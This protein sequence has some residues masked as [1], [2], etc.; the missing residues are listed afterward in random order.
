MP[1]SI[2]SVLAALAAG[3]A[4]ALAA[5]T[6]CAQI[7]IGTIYSA[8]DSTLA[9][10]NAV[11]NTIEVLPEIVGAR[12]YRV[13]AANDEGVPANAARA[14]RKMIADDNVDVVIG[15]T[16][17]VTCAALADIA[18]E[19][20][21]AHLCLVQIPIRNPYVFA[22]AHPI[23]VMVEGIVEHMRAG[24]VKT[25]AFIGTADPWGDESFNQLTRQARDANIAVLSNERY[26]RT[27]KS[28]NP[29][30]LKVVSTQANA[31]MVGASDSASAALAQI[32]L[33]ERGYRGRVY[34]SH[35]ALVRSF[36]ETAGRTAEGALLPSNAFAVLI[37]L[38]E[39][40]TIRRAGIEFVRQFETRFGSGTASAEGAYAWDAFALLNAAIPGALFR[41]VP[42]TEAF[43]VALR[44]ALE[45][46]KDVIGT[47]AVYS[48]TANDHTGVDRRSRV[49]VRVEKGMFR[50]Q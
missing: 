43:R 28:I 27:A 8:N 18:L 37:Q 47:Q 31:V 4:V 24:G 26:P 22:V 35:S 21:V 32:S 34:Q 40:N 45:G 29:G 33:S 9:A 48:M 41:G 36:I 49:M 13:V 19:R 11:R 38:P 10:G 44:D 14:M 20:K 5:G 42:G 2:L 3:A 50:I 46:A 6:A 39:T 23:G 12:P 30:V 15:G 16:T 7:T 17:P 25:V 1:R